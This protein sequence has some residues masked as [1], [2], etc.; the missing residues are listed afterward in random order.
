M[1]REILLK[2]KA[3]NNINIKVEPSL[4]SNKNNVEILLS[5]NYFH[6]IWGEMIRK[7]RKSEIREKSEIYHFCEPIIQIH[8]PQFYVLITN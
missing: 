5:G 3:H 1:S 6:F 4:S 8:M 7:E 2:S